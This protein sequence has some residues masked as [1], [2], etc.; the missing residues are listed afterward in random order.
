MD[1]KLSLSVSVAILPH[2][3]R[4]PVIP[5]RLYQRGT[6]VRLVQQT[7]ESHG[8][9]FSNYIDDRTHKNYSYF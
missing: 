9:K 5:E 8:L 4:N 3:K 7:S 6:H 1:R 2:V